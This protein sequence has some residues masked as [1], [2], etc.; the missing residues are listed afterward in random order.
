VAVIVA[1][2]LPALAADTPPTA[3]PPTQITLLAQA[4]VAAVRLAPA[5]KADHSQTPA[6]IASPANPDRGSWSFFK[7]PGGIIVLSTLAVGVGYF[8][9]STQNDRVTSPGKE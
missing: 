7:S 3:P 6:P 8:I 4:N 1:S 2:P 9:Y 5:L